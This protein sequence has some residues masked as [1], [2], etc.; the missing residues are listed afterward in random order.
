MTLALGAAG[1]LMFQAFNEGIFTTWRENT[2]RI[3]YGHGEVTRVELESHRSETPWEYWFDEHGIEDQLKRHSTQLVELFPRV[4]FVGFLTRGAVTLAGRG[5]GVD[6]TRESSFFTSLNFIAGQDLA[7]PPHDSA[8][9]DSAKLWIILG[10]G[11]ADALQA[12]PGDSILLSG[13]THA[14]QMNGVQLIVRG[15]FHTGSH[16]FDNTFFRI[17][18]STAQSFLDT[19]KIERFAVRLQDRQLWPEFKATIQQASVGT[20]LSLKSFEEIDQFY[21]GNVK[22]FLE[23]QFGVIRVIFLIIVGLGVLSTLSSSFLERAGE[24]GALR[25]NGETRRRVWK[26]WFVESLLLGLIGGAIGVSVAYLIILIGFPTGFDMPPGPGITRE[27]RVH[28]ILRPSHLAQALALSAC[29]SALAS[30]PAIWRLL[31]SPIPL[32]LGRNSQ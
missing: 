13:Q 23:A 11:L 7:P 28:F 12:K 26:I 27:F 5:E 15:V 4:S 9:S 20:Q 32:L 21:Y 1:L 6:P 17:P 16:H 29:A 18:L 31:R 25:A 8:D 3:R 24:L 14:G 19:K 10:K 22:R 30:Q 2:I